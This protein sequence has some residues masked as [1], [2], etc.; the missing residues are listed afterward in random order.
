MASSSF[1]ASEVRAPLIESADWRAWTTPFLFFTG[2]GGVGK[3]TVAAAS[4]IA[5]AD[6]GRRVLVVSTDPASNL[7]DVFGSPVGAEPGPVAGVAGLSAMNL[8]PDAAAAAYRERALAPYRGTVANAE[9]HAIEEQLA[10]ECTVEVAAFDEFTALLV[11]PTLRGSYDHILFDTAPTGHTLRL[12]SLPAAWADYIETNPDAAS[13]LGPGSGLQSQRHQYEAAV[14]Q[15][16]NAESTTLVLVSRPD[17]GSLREAARAGAELAAQGVGNQ[18]LILNGVFGNPLAGDAVAAAFARR[19]SEALAAMPAALASLPTAG[20]PLVAISLTGVEAL[21]ALA[22]G[23]PVTPNAVA[24]EN[25]TSDSPLPDLVALI[26]E[27]AAGPPCAVLVMGKGGVGKTTIAAQIAL[28][29]AARGHETHLSTTD[30]A[31]RPS[32]VIGPPPELLTVSRI[33]PRAELERHT[34]DRLRRAGDLDSERRA[35]LVEDLRSPC[36]QELAVFEAFKNL[37]RQARERFVIVDTAPSGHTLRLLD[38]TGSYHRQAMQTTGQVHRR[39]TTP[40]MRLQ[41]PAFTRVLVVTLPELTPVAE[42]ETLQ[43]R[44]AARW[45]RA[46]RLGDQREPDRQRHTRP[47]PRSPRCAGTAAPPARARPPRPPRLACALAAR[48]H[49]GRL[50]NPPSSL[51]AARAKAEA[52]PGRTRRPIGA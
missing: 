36:T 46:L 26:D 27:L 16:G 30:P 9:L 45:H 41:D 18:R 13:C 31:G 22:T 1:T 21:R 14:R 35:L 25:G 19:Q 51:H 4:A 8:D 29:L 39:V 28:G 44:P 49:L 40:L 20:V 7:A 17:P 6:A 11:D 43:D 42:A 33:D 52:V 23:Q 2:K 5:L 38:L 32:D 37:L 10:G 34:A 15:L 48:R 3:T 24:T 12:M 50:L 47:A